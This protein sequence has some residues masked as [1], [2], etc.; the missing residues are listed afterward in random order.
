MMKKIA[1]LFP[2][3]GYTCDKPLLYYSWKLLA[4]LGWE[5]VPVRYSGF[6]SGVKGDP[7]K[8]LLSA[9]MAQ[10]QAEEILREI[11]WSAY[12]EILFIG[13][14]IGTVVACAYAARHQI[15]CRQ[16]LFTPVESTFQFVET[17][18][19]AFHGT[20]DPWAD[21]KM[22]EK[23][24]AQKGIGLY[25]TK[26]AN[27]SLETGDVDHDIRTMRKTMEIVREYVEANSFASIESGGRRRDQ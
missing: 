4:G 3:I 23:G 6:P 26:G 14:S 7:E 8:M 22:I 17:G 1:C 5:I 10:E 9:Q 25:E 21:T 16:I 27:H 12:S 18:A 11:D 19:I 13:K 24:C 2:G 15:R 20:S